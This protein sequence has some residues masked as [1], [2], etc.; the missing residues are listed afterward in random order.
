MCNH[1][2]F[3]HVYYIHNKLWFNAQR[4]QIGME[5]TNVSQPKYMSSCLRELCQTQRLFGCHMLNFGFILQYRQNHSYLVLLS[6]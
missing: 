3:L 1:M 4:T 2:R 6:L 5:R